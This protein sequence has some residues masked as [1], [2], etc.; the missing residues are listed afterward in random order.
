[1][2]YFRRAENEIERSDPMIR[3]VTFLAA[4]VVIAVLP[5]AGTAAAIGSGEHDRVIVM[6]LDNVGFDFGSAACP[7]GIAS[8]DIA[9]P[10]GVALG[11]GSSCILSFEDCETF[12]VGCRRR[13]ESLFTFALAG[14]DPISVST[15]IREVVLDDDPFTVAQFAIGRVVNGRG[16]L[17]GAGTLAFPSEGIESTLVYVLFLGGER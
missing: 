16:G 11:T 12:A 2:R 8:F 17:F 6:K 15:T 5:A 4:L 3:A 10:D 13:A 7:E 9:S 1:V 14:R